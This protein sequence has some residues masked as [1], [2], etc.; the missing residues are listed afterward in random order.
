MRQFQIGN[1]EGEFPMTRIVSNRGMDTFYANK[2]HIK[3]PQVSNTVPKTGQDNSRTPT[4]K[5][6][7]IGRA[8]L[9][10][11][12]LLSSIVTIPLCAVLEFISGYASGVIFGAISVFHAQKY[13][14]LK[15]AIPAA[16]L[17][18]PLSLLLGIG[19]AITGFF[20][21]IYDGAY[22]GWN[23]DGSKIK[24]TYN[25]LD[26]HAKKYSQSCDTTLEPEGKTM[27]HDAKNT[28]T[29]TP[30]KLPTSNCNTYKQFLTP[31]TKKYMHDTN[32]DPSLN[33]F[34]D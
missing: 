27:P 28:K 1:N 16:L 12:R 33:P 25:T 34:T 4:S 31:N 32:Y 21:G 14:G 11:P 6:R 15:L 24:N 18:I 3:N 9:V 29:N 22:L 19:V 23:C 5:A 13:G 7:K 17:L 26:L 30:P 20:L 2:D 8:L 10:I